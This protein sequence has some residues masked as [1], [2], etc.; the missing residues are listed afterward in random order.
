MCVDRPSPLVLIGMN[1]PTTAVLYP[2]LPPGPSSQTL[3]SS[4]SQGMVHL[5]Q[6]GGGEGRAGYSA[7]LVIIIPSHVRHGDIG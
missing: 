7:T 2:D 4:Y 3:F 1:L 6:A 5:T